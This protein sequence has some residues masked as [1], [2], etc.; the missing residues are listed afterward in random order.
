MGC[1]EVATESPCTTVDRLAA[2]MLGELLEEVLDQV[3]LGQ[4]LEPLDL[5]DRH[6]R[7]V[8]DW[9]GELELAGPVGDE[10][11]EQLAPGDERDGDAGGAASPA[12]LG[13]EL[14]ETDRLRL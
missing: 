4:T 14:A 7:L 1:R 3:L 6:S 13:Q 8:A 5:L 12:H 10:S 2:P 9:A 11:T